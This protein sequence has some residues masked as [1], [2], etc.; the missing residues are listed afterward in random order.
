[1]MLNGFLFVTNRPEVGLM[2]KREYG[3]RIL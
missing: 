3:K 2:K 1:M